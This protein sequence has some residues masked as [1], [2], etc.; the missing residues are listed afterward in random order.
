MFKMIFIF[1]I[2]GVFMKS[3]LGFKLTFLFVI[4][5]IG[6]FLIIPNKIY[7]QSPEFLKKLETLELQTLLNAD[8]RDNFRNFETE[9][10]FGNT[11]L[12]D[13]IRFHVSIVN[14]QPFW[15]FSLNKKNQEDIY[16]FAKINKD[17]TITLLQYTPM[18]T[19]GQIEYFL[20]DYLRDE[21]FRFVSDPIELK[22]MSIFYS[23]SLHIM[24]RKKI[25]LYDQ[26]PYFEFDGFDYFNDY[27]NCNGHVLSFAVG[28]YHRIGFQIL[29]YLQTDDQKKTGQRTFLPNRMK[30]IFFGTILDEQTISLKRTDL[31]KYCR[32]LIF[33]Y[34]WSRNLNEGQWIC[35]KKMFSDLGFKVLEE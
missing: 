34:H 2:Y 5:Y 3:Y 17:E 1:T 25:S 35:I 8:Q 20:S 7:A 19:W 12:G 6:T 14:N 22:I 31:E 21:M 26:Y 23:D 27:W 16:P 24:Y 32:N 11:T 30:S 18:K 33:G 13:S 15:C 29:P 10:I 9:E 4:F 28:F